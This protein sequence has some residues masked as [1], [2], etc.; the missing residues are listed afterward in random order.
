[1]ALRRGPGWDDDAYPADRRR[2]IVIGVAVALLVVG[3]LVGWAVLNAAAH[4]A[5]GV[6]ALSDGSYEGAVTELSA[7]KVLVVPYRDA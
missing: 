2:R 6:E 3:A 7:A 1:M 5:R 4:Y